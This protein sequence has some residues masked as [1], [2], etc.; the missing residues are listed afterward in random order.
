[1]LRFFRTLRQRLLTEGRIGKYLLYAIGEILLVVI[2]ILL[3]LQIDDWNERRKVR[4][5]EIKTLKELHSDL[6]QSYQDIEADRNF[7]EACVVSNEVILRAITQKLPY[8]DSLLP[9]F[10]NLYPYQATF[11]L[12]QTTYDNIRQTGSNLITN[13]SLRID[14][15]D[16]YRGY[17]NMYREMEDR[18]VE[19]HYENSVKPMFLES[20]V[21]L[22]GNQMAPRDYSGFTDNARYEQLLRYNV[23]TLQGITRVQSSMLNGIQNILERIDAEIA[24]LSDKKP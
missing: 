20:F 8:T 14:V 9:H 3:A 6:T 22:Q 11:S 2:G 18:F 4:K 24:R 21:F 5:L 7:M 12:N 19:N 13:D 1:M 17:V 23:R 16:F 10:S 15:S